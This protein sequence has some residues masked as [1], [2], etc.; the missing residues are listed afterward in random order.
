MV[1]E[2]NDCKYITLLATILL[3]N[4]QTDER[5]RSGFTVA[6]KRAKLFAAE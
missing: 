4:L 6:N 1:T 2:K 3:T 5:S